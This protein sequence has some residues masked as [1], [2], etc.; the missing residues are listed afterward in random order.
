[1]AP[2]VILYGASWCPDCDPVKRFLIEHEIDFQYVDIDQDAGAADVVVKLSGG[3]TIPVLVLPGRVLVNPDPA[4]LAAAFAVAPALPEPIY[5]VVI[6]GA[7][8][9]GLSTAIYTTR[10]RLTT[11]ILEKGVPGG[12]ILTTSA[13]ENYPGFPEPISGFDLTDR[14]VTQ[15]RRFGAEILDRHEVIKI[16]PRHDSFDLTVTNSDDQT[17]H[18]LARAVILVPGSNYKRLNVPGEQE[19]TGRGVSYCGTCDAPFYRGKH[20]VAVGG[21]NSA[22]DEGLHL[23]KFVDRLTIVHNR[24]ELAAQPFLIEELM[25]QKDRV[26]ILSRTTVARIEGPDRVTGVVLKDLATGAERPYP[27]DGVFVWIGLRPN[28]DFLRPLVETDAEGFILADDCTMATA[29][30]GLYAAGDC[31]AGSKKQLATASGEGVIAALVAADYLKK[32]K[33]AARK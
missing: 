9:A 27:C 21:G 13:V 16:E 29:V 12:Q 25:K 23:L 28:T 10:E 20:V 18:F 4:A 15:A 26:T 17:K 3:R 6:V 5:D 14:L 7:G 31:R 24:D 1:M 33:T 19:L 30:P 32:Q 8:V 2:N 22:V 11:L